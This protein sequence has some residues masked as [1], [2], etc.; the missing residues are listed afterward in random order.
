MKKFFPHRVLHEIFFESVT[1][2]GA[3]FDSV[4][5]WIQDDCP[6][7]PGLLALYKAPSS[8]PHRRPTVETV[9]EES[10]PP[11]KEPRPSPPS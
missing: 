3:I 7:S 11:E 4:E 2:F 5:G 9:V 6:R 10:Q 8:S 1:N